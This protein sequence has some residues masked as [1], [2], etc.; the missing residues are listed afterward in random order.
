MAHDFS[1]V[2]LTDDNGRIRSKTYWCEKSRLESA[3]KL[4]LHAQRDFEY[5]QENDIPAMLIDKTPDAPGGTRICNWDTLPQKILNIL[6]SGETFDCS[7][8]DGILLHKYALAVM[9][10]NRNFSQGMKHFHVEIRTCAEDPAEE[11]HDIWDF[12][13]VDENGDYD[14]G[15]KRHVQLAIRGTV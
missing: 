6:S 5:C 13:E 2:L 3:R 14:K 1:A 11:P 7:T 15:G 4:K 12:Y 8:Y 10:G 9:D